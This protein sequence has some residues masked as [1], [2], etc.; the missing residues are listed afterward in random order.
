MQD[1]FRRLFRMRL[2]LGMMDPPT[3]NPWNN[4]PFSIVEVSHFSDFISSWHFPPLPPPPLPFPF[5]L[6]PTPF[7]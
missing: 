2:R 3:Y 5:L 1:A 6:L 7:P 4:I